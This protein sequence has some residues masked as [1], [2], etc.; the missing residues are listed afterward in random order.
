MCCVH[1]LA[2]NTNVH[3]HVQASLTR[4]CAGAHY[5]I[6]PGAKLSRCLLCGF[7]QLMDDGDICEACD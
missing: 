1:E 5:F 6:L 7:G 2:S 4:R 3:G